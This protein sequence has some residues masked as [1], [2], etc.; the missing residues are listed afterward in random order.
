MGQIEL[1]LSREK[2][3][4]LLEGEEVYEVLSHR[5]N[6]YNVGWTYPLYGIQDTY[7]KVLS[8]ELVN[9]RSIDKDVGGDEHIKRQCG[10]LAWT[11]G[12]K[13]YVL[14]LVLTSEYVEKPSREV[15][16]L[17]KAWVKNVQ[18]SGMFISKG[19]RYSIGSEVACAEP[20][21]T[22][23]DELG[24]EYKK[25]LS[26]EYH[27]A[28]ED[29]VKIAGWTNRKATRACLMPKRVR[30]IAGKTVKCWDISEAEWEMM[31][32]KVQE[33]TSGRKRREFVGHNYWKYNYPVI[34]YK[35][36]LAQ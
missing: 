22:L 29:L 1:S 13:V 26:E 27:V 3:K 9:I 2:V 31:G 19:T 28:L 20:Y 6:K 33:D 21:C 8:N 34:L 35:Y 7:I 18:Q 11:L 5:A 16:G 12:S 24:D 25:V 4:K 17:K 14:K 10:E 23:V 30:I 36:E 32:I 15:K